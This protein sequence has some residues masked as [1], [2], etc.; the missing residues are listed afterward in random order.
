MNINKLI[1]GTAQFG[2]PYGIENKEVN[3][4]EI[5]NILKFAKKNKINYLDTA[6]VYKNAMKKLSMFNLKDWKIISKIPSK[7]NNIKDIKGWINKVFYK[8]L[9][10]LKIFKIDTILIH[11]ENDIL[12]KNSGD[13]LFRTLNELKS[14]SIVKNV[15]CSIYS[16]KKIKKILHRYDFDIIQSPYN[17]FDTRILSSGLSKSLIERKVKLHLRSIF[18]QGL[19]LKKNNLPK[20]FKNN[21]LLKKFNDWLKKSKNENIAVCL[22]STSRVKFD[23]LIIGVNNQSQLKEIIKN[24]KHPIK[25]IPTF[26]INQNNKLIDP[27]TW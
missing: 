3:L 26:Y 9:D 4:K 22:R 8:S 19:L 7:P 16:P 11:D 1:I 25:K 21:R 2:M 27:R 13:I 5:G 6:P 15:G 23:K 20:K 17:I 18:L 14:N 24:C 10:I 12:N